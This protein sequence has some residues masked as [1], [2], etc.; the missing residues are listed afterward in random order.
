[1][2]ENDYPS[3]LYDWR[4]IFNKN[5]VIDVDQQQQQSR[6]EKVEDTAIGITSRHF[7]KMR[8]SFKFMFEIYSELKLLAGG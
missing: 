1:M 2:V 3:K 6:F 4:M 8:N 5:C 7:W